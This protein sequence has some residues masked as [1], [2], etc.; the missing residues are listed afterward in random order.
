[1]LDTDTNSPQDVRDSA[2]RSARGANS[3]AFALQGFFLALVLTELPQEKE[4]F[5]LDDTMLVMI[6]AGISLL[7]GLGSVI[8]ERVALRWS[9]RTALRIALG[10]VAVAGAGIALSPNTTALVVWLGVYGVALGG[11]DAGTNMQAVLIQHGYGRFILSSFYAAWSTGAILGA[12]WVS[13]AEAAGVST[14][15]TIL[16]AGAVVAVAG[17]GSSPRLLSAA[18]GESG[19]AEHGS[20]RPVPARVLLLF[21]VVLALAFAI[22]LAVGNWSALYLK[23]ELGAPAAIAALALAAY[24]GASLAGRLAGDTLVRRFGPRHVSR[25][26]ALIGAAGLAVVALVP[27]PAAAIAGFL[28]AGIGLPLI[29]PLCFSELGRRTSG[30]GLDAVIARLNL[31]NYAGTLI[32]G[33][34]VGSVAA[35]AGMRAGF[36]IPLLFAL[37]LAGLARTF[38][39][40]SAHA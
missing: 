40:R 3:V 36:A 21:G 23:D 33:A 16:I 38:A 1:M 13:A 22:D 8:A 30:P 15:V 20:P 6:V 12:L 4:K 39:H 26:A 31:F 17:Q 11:V 19:P 7:A 14:P 28:I 18:A 25:V 34:V 27:A 32:G 37:A 5:G 9:S 24:Q 10:L 35:A 2:L 29:A